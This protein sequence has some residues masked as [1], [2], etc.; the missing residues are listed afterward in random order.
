MKK[1]VIGIVVVIASLLLVI[2]WAGH[3]SDNEV[4]EISMAETIDADLIVVGVVQV[5]AESDW[6]VANTQSLQKAF[7]EQNG[8]YM[9][10]VDAQ[11]KQEN[12][13]KAIREFILQD[14]DYIVCAPIVESGW[15]AVLQEA[16]DAGIPVILIDRMV[17]VS[18]DSLYTCW[19]GSDF[20]REGKEAGEWLD[21]YLR[22]EGRNNDRINIVTLQGTTGASAQIGR[23]EGFKTVLNNHPNWNMM[24]MQDGDFTQAKGQEVMEYFLNQYDDIDVVISENDNMTFGAIHAIEE[25]GLTCG[26]EGDIIVVSYDAVYAALVEMTKGNLNVSIECNPLTGQLVSDIIQQMEQGEIPEKIVYVE[27]GIITA[28]EAVD[29][30]SDRKY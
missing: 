28:E 21:F 22:S 2:I 1:N 14:V 15:D 3:S 10:Y 11:Q 6:R 24:D 7:T 16:K 18:D 13:L 5:G 20:E 26:T 29:L 25:A 27:E 4:T 30:L 19:V 12:Q 9:I 17:D 23:T 8:Y